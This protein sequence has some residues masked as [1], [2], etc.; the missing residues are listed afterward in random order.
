MIK[1]ICSLL[2]FILFVTAT[3]IFAQTAPVKVLSAKDVSTFVSNYTTI[4][5]DLEEL[6]DTY[7]DFFDSELDD[8]DDPVQ[9][10]TQLRTLNVP[11]AIQSVFKKN[12]MGDKGFEKYVVITM[13]VSVL[14]MIDTMEEQKQS[15]AA[16]PEMQPYLVAVEE[17]IKQMRSSIH[18]ADL[19]LI[20][21][22]L[23]ELITLIGESE[24]D[25]EYDDEND[26]Y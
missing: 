20:K 5:N 2:C 9:A 16:Q 25:E 15:Y 10:L 3:T 1:K 21:A 13:G 24:Y 26:F 23:P 8:L 7:E 12:G 18:Q 6:G 17:M 19:D 4:Q 11:A 14:F 22:R